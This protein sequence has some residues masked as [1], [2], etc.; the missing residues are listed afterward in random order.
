MRCYHYGM[1]PRDPT[2]ATLIW[3]RCPSMDMEVDAGSGVAFSNSLTFPTIDLGGVERAGNRYLW[4]CQN[5]QQS[6]TLDAGVAVA[7]EM[8]TP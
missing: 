6:G 3:T 2:G 1:D 8:I 4:A 7:V 5:C